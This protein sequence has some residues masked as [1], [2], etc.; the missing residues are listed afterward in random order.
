ME[1]A[2]EVLGAWVVL[3]VIT[4]GV[5]AALFA[6]GERGERTARAARRPVP[7]PGPRRESSVEDVVGT[8]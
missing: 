3:A 7:L 8:R 5:T 4:V 2:A 6:G 1:I